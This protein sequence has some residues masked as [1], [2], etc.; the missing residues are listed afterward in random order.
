MNKSYFTIAAMI[1]NTLAAA[2]MTQPVPPSDAPSQDQ[3]IDGLW[4]GAL[5]IAGATL[6]MADELLVLAEAQTDHAN[7]LAACGAVL[8]AVALAQAIT[9]ALEYLATKEQIEYGTP[10]DDSKASGLLASSFRHQMLELPRLASE[11][12]Y[13]LDSTTRT[14]QSLNKLIDLRNSL[15][16]WSR[17]RCFV[18]LSLSTFSRGCAEVRRYGFA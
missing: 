16:N 9:T 8:S 12:R 10:R 5:S 3:S 13:E 17:G 6:Q 14:Y 4:E 11:G 7:T 2:T 1:A 15:M 18:P